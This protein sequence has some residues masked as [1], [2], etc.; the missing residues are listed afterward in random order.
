MED[1]KMK[2]LI[3]LAIVLMM[4]LSAGALAETFKMG[5][6]AAYPPFSYLGEDGA[7]T[8]FDVEMCALV[9]AD[10]GLEQEVVPINWDSKL[11]SLEAGEIDCIWSGLTIDVLDP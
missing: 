10:L 9:C 4:A 6:D 1:T 2:K 3:A 7:Y 8:G 5:I 11:L